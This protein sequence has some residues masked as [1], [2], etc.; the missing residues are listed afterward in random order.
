MRVLGA[1]W[2]GWLLTVAEEVLASL[3]RIDPLPNR[4]SVYWVV[5][6]VGLRVRVQPLTPLAAVEVVRDA[7]NDNVRVVALS[8][9]SEDDV[10]A[11]LGAVLVARA[12]VRHVEA[13]NAGVA[14]L[15]PPPPQPQPHTAHS[16]VSA[17]RGRTSDK[18]DWPG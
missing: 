17:E 5:V 11:A 12:G 16:S 13:C 9:D 14:L 10:L 8:A 1:G 7:G 18:M 2:R 15:L 6:V 3:K 4:S